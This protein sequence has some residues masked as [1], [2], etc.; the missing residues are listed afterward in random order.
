MWTQ[1]FI[2]VLVFTLFVLTSHSKKEDKKYT[3][4]IQED[5][6]IK[7]TIIVSNELQDEERSI[8]IRSE[9]KNMC[10]EILETVKPDVYPVLL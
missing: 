8:L 6:K 10:D 7:P 5:L 3:F 4:N 9:I 2:H 1:R